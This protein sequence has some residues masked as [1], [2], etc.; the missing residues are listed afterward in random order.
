MSFEG[1]RKEL[2]K[3]LERLNNW[4][5]VIDPLRK[6][7][8]IEEIS[9]QPLADKRYSQNDIN[10]YRL[11]LVTTDPAHSRAKIAHIFLMTLFFPVTALLALIVGIGIC[12]NRSRLEV[13]LERVTEIPKLV[14]NAAQATAAE[15][16]AAEAA[17]AEAGDVAKPTV[18]KINP[19]NPDPKETRVLTELASQKLQ[20]ERTAAIMKMARA[21]EVVK[22]YS[23]ALIAAKDPR[24]INLLLIEAVKEL[25]AAVTAEMKVA[26]T[27]GVLVAPEK[28]VCYLVIHAGKMAVFEE[29]EAA[30]KNARAKGGVEMQMELLAAQAKVP[31][32]AAA[33]AEQVQDP[34]V[35]LAAQA[36][37][38]KA[39][40][41]K[42]EKEY[43]DY[44][45]DSIASIVALT[46]R[47]AGGAVPK[48]VHA[49]AAAQV[50]IR[51]WIVSPMSSL[52]DKYQKALAAFKFAADAAEAGALTSGQSALK[53]RRDMESTLRKYAQDKKA[54]R[55]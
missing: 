48:T 8:I 27:T 32:V 2:K 36:V 30:L 43:L 24:L 31:V 9:E 39:A 23:V 38:L 37:F 19:S 34:V 35:L 47:A 1:V 46:I 13:G 7:E 11:Q 42:D 51:E 53:A 25:S 16:A 49:Q 41:E 21:L 55:K 4:Q 29:Q 54:A 44:A 5:R 28:S 45:M 12:I 10:H 14:C 3:E 18:K 17:E 33:L 26:A 22:G 50:A 52:A 15:K 20:R 40:L 6:F